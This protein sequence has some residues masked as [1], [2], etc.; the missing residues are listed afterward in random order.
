[1]WTAAAAVSELVQMA[2]RRMDSRADFMA[3]LLK[4]KRILEEL[5]PAD[6]FEL[7]LLYRSIIHLEGAK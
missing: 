1:M 6:Q 7:E 3:Y 4:T 5:D 2:S